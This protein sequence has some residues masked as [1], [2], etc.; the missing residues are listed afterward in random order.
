M[1]RPEI[2]RASNRA[3]IDNLFNGVPPYTS[4]EEKENQIYVNVNWKEGVNALHAARGQYENAFLKPG[5]FFK[6]TLDDAP[7][8]KQA[9]WSRITTKEINKALKKSRAYLHTQRSKFAGVCLHGVGCQM[10][11][12]KDNPIP[13]DVGMK[14]LLIPSEVDLTLENLT[15]FAVRRKMRPGMLYKK[16]IAKGANVDPGWKLDMVKKLLDSK[17]DENTQSGTSNWVNNPE[18]MAEL[19]KQNVGYYDS[20]KAPEFSFWDFYWIEDGEDAD[21][22]AGWYRVIILDEDCDNGKTGTTDDP[23]QF[24]YESS[25]A[26]A[27]N[28]DEFIHFQFGDGN[29]V[30]PFKYHSIRSLGWLLF[31]VLQLM[32]RLR[33]QFTQHVFE[34]MLTLMRI[35]E[36]SDRARA[37]K[38]LLFN[39]GVLPDGVSL[40]P[41]NERY[42]VDFNLVNGLMA[43]MKQ[44]ISESSA[45]YTQEIDSG[46]QKERTKFEVEAIMSQI[47]SLM[48]SML[49]LAYIQEFFAYL[50]ICRRFCKENSQSFMVKKFRNE[51]KK[52]G[53]PENMLNVERWT[54]AV[55][56]VLGSGNKMLE[57]AQARE[58]RAMRPTLGP[59]AQQ[60]VDRIYIGALTDNAKLAEA[61]VPS[62]GEVT[63]SMHDAE[64][65]FAPLMQGVDMSVKE[66]LNHHEQITTL[67]KLMGMKIKS[68]QA[69]G[70]VGTP[71][72]TQGLN[73]VAAFITKHL[74]ILSQNEDEKSSI[75][76]YGDILKN[77]MNFVRAFEQ[78]QEQ[79]AKAE[80]G[81]GTDPQAQLELASAAQMTKIKL[82]GKAAQDQQKLEHKQQAFEQDQAMKVAAAKLDNQLKQMEAMSK[83]LMDALQAASKPEKKESPS[84][85]PA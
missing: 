53:I 8:D 75:K 57:I 67:L 5:N 54:I 4:Q 73:N 41:A 47:T 11:E 34:Q 85:T 23:I 42:S 66:G 28:L 74:E 72:E 82:N 58:L 81:D 6:V 61:L 20:D 50:E 17:K 68:I 43:N 30:P 26:Y 62:S 65:A 71:Q 70:G 69:S 14:D 51:C 60:E 19:Y 25:V 31:D 24:V 22:P 63:D 79:E 1:K 76:Q 3:L 35:S 49:N 29:N 84:A 18:Q 12:D 55:E 45:S 52:Q 56:Q 21:K 10:W 64:L 15:Y 32:N 39:N 37:M 38:A 59:Q 78:R 7:V 46:T 80:Q 83:A 33:C 77:F 40:V 9:E 16:T 27:D 13:F 48:S 2:D 44:L 36:P